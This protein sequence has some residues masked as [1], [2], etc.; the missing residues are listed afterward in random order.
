[1]GNHKKFRARTNQKPTTTAKSKPTSKASSKATMPLEAVSRVPG[2]KNLNVFESDG[3]RVNRRLK[4]A[5]EDNPQ[6][7]VIPQEAGILWH[8]GETKFVKR[9]E[10]FNGNK[11][12]EK[13]W[14]DVANPLRKL[15]ASTIAFGIQNDKSEVI[16]K[17]FDGIVKNY[18]IKVDKDSRGLSGLNRIKRFEQ[19]LREILRE[20][21]SVRFQV[22]V[23]GKF[24][25]EIDGVKYDLD[26]KKYP[27]QNKW[28]S[29][30]AQNVSDVKAQGKN[31]LYKP[32]TDMIKQIRNTIQARVL[33]TGSDNEKLV[34]SGIVFDSIESL[35]MNVIKYNPLN[36]GT[37]F[38]TTNVI[39]DKV[40]VVNVRNDGQGEKH[41]YECPDS[42]KKG[43]CVHCFKHAIVAGLNYKDK[44][45]DRYRLSKYKKAIQGN[46]DK[47]KWD[48]INFPTSFED[49][50]KFEKDNPEIGLT[51]LRAETTE[52][53]TKLND[54]G[55]YVL[56][57]CVSKENDKRRILWLLLI[58]EHYVY[59]PNPE[60]LLSTQINKWNIGSVA[61]CPHCMEV[62]YAKKKTTKESVKIVEDKY[63]NAT[64]MSKVLNVSIG[65]CN[66]FFK[67]GSFIYENDLK[68]LKFNGKEKEEYRET[69]K[70][71]EAKER[72]KEHKKRL[73]FTGDQKIPP[74]IH[75]MP[76]K[77]NPDE[78]KMRFT[79]WA[80]TQKVP[81]FITSDFEST[82]IPLQND[83]K[84][85]TQKHKVNSYFIYATCSF[86][87]SEFKNG[88]KPDRSKLRMF[89]R[90][91]SEDDNVIER[92]VKDVI[93]IKDYILDLN[94]KYE[95]Q[96]WTDEQKERRKKA[97]QC[98]LCK[99]K[100]EGEK[101][102]DKVIDH[103]HLRGKVCGI[104]CKKCNLERTITGGKY[105]IPVFFH[106]LKGY[107]SHFI[108]R[109]AHKY[110]RLVGGSEGFGGV[111]EA[112]STKK[113]KAVAS[114]EKKG[115]KVDSKQQNNSGNGAKMEVLNGSS[116]KVLTIQFRNLKFIDSL[117]FLSLS[118][119]SLVKNLKAKEERVRKQK[120]NADLF[121]ETR[122][123]FKEK[124]PGKNVDMLM[125]KGIY[126]YEYITSL[127]VFKDEKLPSRE[128]FFSSLTDE[129]VSEK[130]YKY[131]EEVWKEFGCKTLGDYHDIYLTLDVCLLNDVMKSFRDTAFDAWGID[132][133]HRSYF[134]LAKYSWECMLKYT[135]EFY[136]AKGEDFYIQLLDDTQEDM[137]IFFEDAKRG[138][139]SYIGN[140]HATANNPY[141]AEQYDEEQAKKDGFDIYIFYWDANNL[142]SVAQSFP[143]PY[144]DFEWLSDEDLEKLEE[145]LSQ[146]QKN[147]KEKF[148]EMNGGGEACPMVRDLPSV[149][150]TTDTT[151]YYFEVD[152]EIPPHLHERFNNFPMAVEKRQ[153]LN[154]ELSPW[155]IRTQ[156]NR[157]LDNMSE[158]KKSKEFG[159]EKL[160]PS[161]TNKKKYKCH[162]RN[163]LFYLEEGMTVS[164]IHRVISYTQ[165][166]FLRPY[167][168]KNTEFRKNASN[169]FEKDYYKLALNVIFGKSIENVRGYSDFKL[170]TTQKMVQNASKDL[171]MKFPIKIYHDSLVGA[172]FHKKQVS[173]NKPIFIGSS[174]MEI[175][176][177][178]MYKFYYEYVSPRYNEDK[179]GKI[180]NRVKLLMTDTDSMC[181]QIKTNSDLYKDMTDERGELWFD[182]SNL[183]EQLYDKN[184]E[185]IKRSEYREKAFKFHSNERKKELGMF[186]DETSGVP[187]ADFVGLRSKMYSLLTIE[188]HHKATAKGVDKKKQKAFTHLNYYQTLQGVKNPSNFITTIRI[189]AEK[190]QVY[191][192]KQTKVGLANFDDKS[193]IC[194]DGVHTLR[195][196][197]KD[198]EKIRKKEKSILKMTDEVID[199]LLDKVVENDD[200]GD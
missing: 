167:V 133:F 75:L 10:Y 58:N 166:D 38:D 101:D 62:F 130:D 64:A 72:L 23:K 68:K 48:N 135:A 160:I 122:R 146:G 184:G 25:K 53:K 123:F 27:T 14:D 11:L 106:N 126:P 200:G 49:V 194:Y 196:G 180:T 67:S 87:D 140:R 66:K 142:Y 192:R 61:I 46:T 2:K 186:K 28:I 149:D 35:S 88:H 169:E 147:L 81:W 4:T 155:Q 168:I 105:Q 19:R 107:D 104:A 112:Q 175:S 187:I 85:N 93:E 73:C 109:E 119:D 129:S 16:E 152:I 45:K 65:V 12:K 21:S 121:P 76:K 172:D 162:L 174:I 108:I 157:K 78:C 47:L 198:I 5:L 185:P 173:L 131:A 148:K 136:K 143:M 18:E 102:K 164:K 63:K 1:M 163:L 17:A 22:S 26:E 188:N 178:W 141:L 191:T 31:G 77:K 42:C 60:K 197:H 151:G 20:H 52:D 179:Q 6:S 145:V 34:G 190:H 50:E 113:K 9:S 161:L 15:N 79:N 199:T 154:G 144:K 153:V 32:L 86:P 82:L 177:L 74:T 127:D 110:L 158:E 84:G 128:K 182:R 103:C 43:K 171:Y 132:P 150:E 120:P 159:P 59:V 55:I 97:K 80:A 181:L 24:L 176:K 36:G 134:T 139:V 96:Q 195:H 116:E 165:R 99:K 90:A 170:M 41:L 33:K 13:Y 57:S 95:K 193:Y 91:T 189:S 118:L 37:W 92:F 111:S 3:K 30:D 89:Y 71:V 40:G 51:V 94:R 70:K 56:R 8:A 69:L 100:F 39:G 54:D 137:Y 138:G 83:E 98:Y 44:D 114:L 115:V 125:R 156:K 117:G 29:A 7:Y 124:Y 183:G